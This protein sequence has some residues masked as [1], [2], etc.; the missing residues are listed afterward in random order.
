[1]IAPKAVLIAAV[2]FAVVVLLFRYVSLGSI[3][4]V[5]AFPL[6]VW[7]LH[8]YG[9][10]RMALIFMCMASLL[11]IVRHHE[12]IRRLLAGGESRFGSRKT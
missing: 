12:N 8:E 3:L 10:S 9:N 6:L 11:I 5:A 2:I 1:M 4:S 7:I